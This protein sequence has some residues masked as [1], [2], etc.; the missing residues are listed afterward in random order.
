MPEKTLEEQANDLL[1]ES[2]QGEGVSLRDIGILDERTQRR[3]AGE[4]EVPMSLLYTKHRR[5]VLS[6]DDFE[7]DE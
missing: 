5:G 1:R 4:Y 2:A 7:E 6:L 3:I